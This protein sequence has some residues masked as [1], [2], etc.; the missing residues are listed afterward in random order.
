M[1]LPRRLRAFSSCL[2]AAVVVSVVCGAS[3]AAA[4]QRAAAAGSTLGAAAAY[5]PPAGKIFQGVATLPL[6]AYTD[7]VGQ[8]PAVYQEFV[9]WGEYVPDITHDA[10]DNRARMMMM[11]STNYGSRD[12]IT[13]QGIANGKGD[14]WLIALGRQI[15]ASGNVTYMRLMAEMDNYNNSYCGFNANGSSRGP[16]FSPA[17]FRQA[18]RRVTLI[19]RGGSVAAIDAKLKALKLPKLATKAASLPE[20]KVAMVWVP[21][22]AGDPDIAANQPRDYFPGKAYVDWVGTDFYSRYPNFKGLTSFYNA[23]S[24]YPFVFG[25]YALWG[26]DSPAWVNELFS[27]VNHH[28]E[29][30]MLVYNDD[31]SEF[32]LASYPK[33]ALALRKQLASPKFLAYAP[34]WRP[35]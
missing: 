4:G 23:Y 3:A 1:N 12:A 28:S 34:E 21:M 29:V 14:G 24:K 30:G 7:Y 18:W 9:A 8:H 27:W 16:A 26:D 2:T 31:S 5:R 32:R 6:S 22:V 25:E 10:T 13:P 35:Q 33:S 20:G 11:I 19:L 17:E 15:A